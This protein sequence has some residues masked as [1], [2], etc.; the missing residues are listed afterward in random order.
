[1]KLKK[2]SMLGAALAMMV[3][4]AHLG[5]SQEFVK[6][7][8]GLHT[9]QPVS[10]VSGN[11]SSVGSDTLNNLMTLWAEDPNKLYP[12]VKIQVEGKGSSTAPPAL[13][14]GTAQLGP[15]SRPMKEMEIDQFN[16]KFDY[17][18]EPIRVAIDALAVFANKDNPVKCLTPVHLDA[19][20]SKSRRS[21]YKEDIKTA[22]IEELMLDLKERYIIVIVTQ[23][24]NKQPWF[25]T[26]RGLW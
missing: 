6:L 8:P 15:M 24:C 21:G 5:T 7:D 19:I 10:G 26:M 20:F 16:S 13:I 17:K 11:L 14:S 12:N 18:P 4:T 1:M 25:R 22:K 2:F 3:T 23:I 9:Y